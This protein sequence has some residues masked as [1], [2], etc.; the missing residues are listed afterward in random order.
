[1]SCDLATDLAYSG[2]A[3][4]LLYSAVVVLFWIDGRF[5]DHR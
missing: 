4:L 3:L 1:M 2:I 5:G